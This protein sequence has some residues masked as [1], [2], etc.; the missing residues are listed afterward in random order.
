M[1]P[2]EELVLVEGLMLCTDVGENPDDVGS[3]GLTLLIRAKDL[4]ESL[5]QVEI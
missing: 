3:D 5:N 1:S 2:V 4:T